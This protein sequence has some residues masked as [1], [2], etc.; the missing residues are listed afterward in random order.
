MTDDPTEERLKQAIAAVKQH[1]RG[2]HPWRRAMN[3][4]I[5]E[6]QNLPG[7]VKSSHPDYPE[8]LNDTFLR[9]SEEIQAFDPQYPS[10][11]QSLTAWINGKL[12]LK[13]AVREL[14]SPQR[15]PKPTP[16]PTAKTEFRQQTRK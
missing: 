5:V 14:S 1:P 13:Y 16:N 6:I 11:A 10:I 12:R 7:L 8:A 4:L 2:S 9:L 15:S 3:Q